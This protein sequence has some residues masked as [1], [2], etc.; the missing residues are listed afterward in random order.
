MLD[1]ILGGQDGVV[2]YEDHNGNIV[3]DRIRLP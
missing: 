2:T 1:R 3:Q